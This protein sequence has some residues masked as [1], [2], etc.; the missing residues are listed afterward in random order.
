MGKIWRLLNCYQ[1]SSEAIRSHQNASKVNQKHSKI[2]QRYVKKHQKTPAFLIKYRHNKDLKKMNHRF[3]QINTDFR[4]TEW[5]V[6]LG[7]FGFVF[8]SSKQLICWHNL[9]LYNGLGLFL[10]FRKL[11]SFR[12]INSVLIEFSAQGRQSSPP[13][14]PPI[15]SGQ[16]R[17]LRL[18][19]PRPNACRGRQESSPRGQ[20]SPPN[21]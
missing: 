17:T 1:M 2:H 7:S 4:Q 3:T 6:K 19:V 12:I 11:G 14:W 13:P 15:K 20:A 21:E 16:R 8:A 10:A 18:P 9:L 5:R